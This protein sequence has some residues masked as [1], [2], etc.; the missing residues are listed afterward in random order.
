VQWP[1]LRPEP[2]LPIFL[3]FEQNHADTVLCQMERGGK[4]RIASA[5]DADIGA[6]PLFR[7]C[8]SAARAQQS[9][10]RERFY[11]RILYLHSIISRAK[12]IIWRELYAQLSISAATAFTN[13]TV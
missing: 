1:A 10:A 2:P 8:S 9:H 4:S 13:Q 7:V 3:G 6:D 12:T 5:N 11:R